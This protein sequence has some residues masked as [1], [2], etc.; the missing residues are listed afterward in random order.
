[1]RRL[2][3]VTLRWPR[4]PLIRAMVESLGD[5]LGGKNDNARN[6]AVCC[7]HSRRP[8]DYTSHSRP[9]SYQI[10]RCHAG[11][12]PLGQRRLALLLPS[13]PAPADR[14]S[15]A[16]RQGPDK[17]VHVGQSHTTLRLRYTDF[18]CP[19]CM[20]MRCDRRQSDRPIVGFPKPGCRLI[21]R[22]CR[23]HAAE[24]ARELPRRQLQRLSQDILRR[25]CRLVC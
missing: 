17:T 19:G 1:M 22:P 18:D 2:F 5:G 20:R 10:L 16:R 11:A 7:G 25:A 3:S 13:G 4:R 23:M 8:I 15:R 24:Q 14:H 21:S 9:R 6:V 12:V